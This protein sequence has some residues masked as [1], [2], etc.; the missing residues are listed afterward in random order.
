MAKEFVDSIVAKDV[1][2]LDWV[3]AKLNIKVSEFSEFLKGK[4]DFIESNKGWLTINVLSSKDRTKVYCQ[5][6]DWQP[7]EEVTAADHSPDRQDDMP[8]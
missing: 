2:Q 1:P 4:A 3:K 7:K 8:F 5:F 6:D